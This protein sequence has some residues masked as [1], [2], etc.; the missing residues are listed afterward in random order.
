MICLTVKGSVIDESEN[1][2]NIMEEYMEIL[3][4]LY[5]SETHEWVKVDNNI[6]YIGITDYAQKELGQIVYVELPSENTK[7]SVGDNLGSIEA[8]KSVADIVTPLS[9]IIVK[10]NEELIDNPEIINN[11]PFGDGWLV[12]IQFSEPTDLEL[13][14]NADSYRKLIG[15]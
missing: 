1:R 10:V 2:Y 9:G 6:A 14:M 12:K 7:I 4:D 15:E 13:L 3:D 5:Y 8:A 11:S